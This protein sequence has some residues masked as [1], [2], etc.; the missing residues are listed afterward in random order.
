[1]TS[2]QVHRPDKV[3]FGE[4]GYT[5]ADLAEYFEQL[6]D[7]LLPHLRDRPL[8]LH[9]FPDGVQRPGFFQ[10]QVPDNAP[11]FVHT[12]TVAA[13]NER[14]HVRHVLADSTETL[15]FLADQACVELH[16]WLSRADRVN[17]PDLL[18]LDLD[19][20]PTADL[21]ALR[22]TARASVELFEA[23]ALVP[24]L[25]ATGSSGY[26]V[27]A[28]LDGSA[29]FD[30]VRS[31]T[32]AMADR[33]ASAAPDERTTERSIRKRGDRIFLDTNRNAYAQTAIVPYSP[34]AR[35]GAP[36]ATPIELRELG[37]V[38]PDGFDP[39]SVRRRLAQKGDPWATMHDH[40]RRPPAGLPRP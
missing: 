2:Q 40:A 17:N 25:M 18:V 37:K 15:R 11:E 20:P 3:L 35:P 36:V 32:Q 28:P 9:R 13:G 31:L 23:A 19:P 8:V 30:E 16:R 14:G 34:R 7:V 26:H 29:D 12:A 33:L 1:M 10:K 39:R 5:K 6:A 38:T 24:F 27:V 4:I 21:G 22:D